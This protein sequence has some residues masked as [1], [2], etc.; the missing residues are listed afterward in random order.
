MDSCFDLVS[1]ASLFTILSIFWLFRSF[2]DP[3]F[4]GSIFVCG[5]LYHH[6]L[7]SSI[8]GAVGLFRSDML[9]I[10]NMVWPWF[11]CGTVCVCPQCYLI[12]AMTWY[13]GF[14]QLSLVTRF[15]C[16]IGQLA[17]IWN[18]FHLRSSPAEYFIACNTVLK[19]PNKVE[20]SVH[21]CNSWLSVWTLSYHC[22]VKLFT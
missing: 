6:V 2:T 19:R 18:E 15:A 11:S 1:L 4:T 12:A 21:G 16:D 13:S 17:G 22:P 7:L 10:F 20:R 3:A 9:L 5:P 8:F 14:F